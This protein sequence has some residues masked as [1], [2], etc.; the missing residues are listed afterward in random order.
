MALTPCPAGPRDRQRAAG[1]GPESWHSP[2][3]TTPSATRWRRT[4]QPWWKLAGGKVLGSRACTAW[5]PPTSPP[6]CRRPSSPNA[7]ALALANAGADFT[8]SVRAG[9]GLRH[10]Q[11]HEVAALVAY[12]NDIHALGIHRAQG[13]LLTEPGYRNQNAENHPPS[14]SALRKRSASAELRAGRR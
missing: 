12:I 8:N 3:P 5:V 7:Q 10:Q 2:P 13:L 11:G 6:S 4:P 9:A 1:S 14:P